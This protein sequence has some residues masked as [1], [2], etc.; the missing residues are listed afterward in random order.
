MGSLVSPIL[1][2]VFMEWLETI[3]IATTP[4]PT[5]PRLWKRYVDDVLEIVQKGEIENLTEHLNQVDN[6][7]AITFTH[8]PEWDGQIPFLDTLI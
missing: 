5:Q 8:E 2:N 3:A 1:A 6:T 4:E 7:S